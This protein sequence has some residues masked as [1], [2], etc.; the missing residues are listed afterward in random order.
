[1][2]TPRAYECGDTPG[3]GAAAT[4][5]L[6]MLAGAVELGHGDVLRWDVPDVTRLVHRYHGDPAVIIGIV[7]S[8]WLTTG[9]EAAWHQHRHRHLN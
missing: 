1:M 3:C 4:S 7:A 8:A 6:Y 5:A 2:C 9:L